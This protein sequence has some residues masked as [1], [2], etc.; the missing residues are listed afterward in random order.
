MKK[1]TVALLLACVM[2]L[3][4]AIGGTMAWLTAKTPEVKNVFT[5]SDISIELKEHELN[6]EGTGL[7][8]K[9]TTTGNNNYKMI[10][11]WTIPKDPWVTVEAGSEACY[12][13]VKVTENLGAW[14]NNKVED[15]DPVFKDYLDYSVITTGDKKWTPVDGMTD[16]YYIVIGNKTI[17]ATDYPILVSNQI[18]VSGRVTKEMMNEV[19]YDDDKPTLTF[20]AA[21]VQYYETNGHAFTVKEAFAKTP[22]APANP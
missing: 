21:A 19:T 11:G 3:G 12:L 10:P 17:A 16:V 1:R 5:T 8:D 14:S 13:F 18:A 9:V 20:Q 7:T 6:A 22:F 2:A 4:V 15:R